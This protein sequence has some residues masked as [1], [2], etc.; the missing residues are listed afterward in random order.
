MLRCPRKFEDI[1]TIPLKFSAKGKAPRVILRFREAF[2][3]GCYFGER[4]KT[5]LKDLKGST[6]S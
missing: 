6:H 4:G 2:T 3:V 5:A 1:P